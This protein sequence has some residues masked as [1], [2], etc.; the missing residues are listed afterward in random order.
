MIES[1][2]STYCRKSLS[3]CER[4]SLAVRMSCIHAASVS[5]EICT[6]WGESRFWA[7]DFSESFCS[8][9]CSRLSIRSRNR[10]VSEAGFS[11]SH[12]T[13]SQAF[14]KT[15]SKPFCASGCVV[16]PWC[17]D[18]AKPKYSIHSGVSHVAFSRTRACGGEERDSTIWATNR[19]PVGE[20]LS[21]RFLSSESVKTLK[22]TFY[23]VD[24]GRFQLDSNPM[25]T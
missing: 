22:S 14:W 2:A 21:S 10:Q 9:R 5:L 1:T 19:I 8:A 3:V 4:R 7:V 24:I 13:D 23:Q 18:R 20:S 11:I 15:V 16:V 17:T 6:V 12:R 25:P